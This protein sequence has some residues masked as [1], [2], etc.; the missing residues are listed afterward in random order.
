MPNILIVDD[1]SGIRG[2]L[3]GI[4]EEEGYKTESIASA[5]KHEV[6]DRIEFR[7]G[8]VLK[9]KDLSSASVVMMYMGVDVNLKLRPIFENKT[10]LNEKSHA[11]AGDEPRSPAPSPSEREGRAEILVPPPSATQSSSARQGRG[12]EGY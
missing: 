12:G 7:V 3:T 9:I 8:D 1:E 10:S 5:K 4:F 6:S 11:K 2:S